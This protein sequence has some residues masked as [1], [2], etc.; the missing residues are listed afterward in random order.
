MFTLTDDCTIYV[1]QYFYNIYIC[2]SSMLYV[3]KIKHLKCELSLK[4][5]YKCNVRSQTA[6]LGQLMNILVFHI[7]LWFVNHKVIIFDP[8]Q[9]L[10]RWDQI[11]L[12]TQIMNTVV[13]MTQLFRTQLQ[14]VVP[15]KQMLFTSNYNVSVIRKWSQCQS[16]HVYLCYMDVSLT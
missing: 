6:N 12:M 8:Y 13:F 4:L 7:W 15:F 3:G 5:M 10:K 9:Q 2:T 14:L 16:V 1:L 11:E